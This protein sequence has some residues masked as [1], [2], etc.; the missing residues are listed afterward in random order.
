MQQLQHLQSLKDLDPEVWVDNTGRYVQTPLRPQASKDPISNKMGWIK[1]RGIYYY[2]T[3]PT[4]PYVRLMKRNG[5][6]HPI[7]YC[8]KLELFDR[9]LRQYNDGY[10]DKYPVEIYHIQQL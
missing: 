3:N 10:F 1:Y 6:E 9:F 8:C 7:V 5:L 2:S 4:Y